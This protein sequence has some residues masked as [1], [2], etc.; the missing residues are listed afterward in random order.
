MKPNSSILSFILSTHILLSEADHEKYLYTLGLNIGYKLVLLFNIER[1]PSLI[2]LLQNLVYN[3]L[4]KL[5]TSKREITKTD[6]CY[7]LFESSPLCSRF[8][9]DENLCSDMLEAGII[10]AYIRSSGFVCEV[11]AYPNN[12]NGVVYLLRIDDGDVE[13]SMNIS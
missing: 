5:Y 2:L 9:D 8:M 7:V 6:K 1:E 3:F 10:E 11:E 4:P 12:E 13:R